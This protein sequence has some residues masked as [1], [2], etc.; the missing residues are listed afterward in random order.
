MRKLAT[1]ILVLLC[2]ITMTGLAE[3]PATYQLGD[4]IED[5]SVTLSDGTEVS[6]Y[7]LLGEKKAVLLN[8]W[9]SWCGPC[10]IEF[11]YMEQA[12][13]EMSDEIGVIALSV[14]PTDTDE[15]VRALKESL[16]L[17]T[18]P[19]GLDR[20]LGDRFGIEAFPTTVM[21]DR[22]GIIC[23]Q[24]AGSLPDKDK[25]LRLFSVFTPE[26]YAQP[27]LL[28]EIP[29]PKPTVEAPSP[30]VLKSALQIA[31]DSVTVEASTEKDAWAFLPLEGETGVSASNE[32]VKETKAVLTLRVNA[33]AGE[34]LAYEY[35]VACPAV[36][37]GLTASVDGTVERLYAGQTDWTK[38]SI[39]FEAAG[40]HEITF[41]F[42][43]GASLS[44]SGSARLR[45]V[46]LLPA[47]DVKAQPAA[48]A[49]KTLP[50]MEGA[51]QA[52][53]GATKDILFKETMPDGTESTLTIPVAQG[54][55][56]ILRVQI[57][58]D[59]DERFAFIVNDSD[60]TLLSSLPQDEEGFLYEISERNG[61]TFYYRMNVYANAL[62][63]NAGSLTDDYLCFA[64]ESAVDAYIQMSVEQYAS[65]GVDNYSASWEYVDGSPK[66][67][68]ASAEEAQNATQADY[69]FH[70]RDEEDKPVPGAMIQICDAG[71]CQV[72][73][74]DG[75][76]NAAL[77]GT[78]Y[79]YEIHLL[80]APEGYQ[81]DS[82]VYTMPQEGGTLTITVQKQ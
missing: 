75:E 57:G 20:G 21:V 18:L 79:P 46:S 13:N 8:F 60:A 64:S 43:R 15:T 77:T 53:P 38:D 26:D 39:A 63:L 19:M 67:A 47:G 58:K 42:S 50:G 71:T 41:A 80:K 1:I 66:A 24:E 9:A 22:N 12:Y 32:S 35:A 45:G 59:V 27:V 3:Q 49:P 81:A 4:K 51:I 52:I 33:Q 48:Q 5:F 70:V 29:A 62:D 82:Q 40:E 73:V 17:K 11:P 7:A 16:G 55:P 65:M 36:Y 72:V 69:V 6:L 2:C 25:F 44:D 28:S 74:T 78:P 68:P 23:F 14:E 56:L 76:G 37:D 31:D 54:D 34:A 30:D 61:E 10:R